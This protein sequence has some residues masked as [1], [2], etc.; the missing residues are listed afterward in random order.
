M[1]FESNTG[2]GVNNYYGPRDTGGTEGVV[3]TE[4]VMNEFMKDY[5]NAET[6]DFGFPVPLA[7]QDSYW[8]TEVDV[9]QATGTIT[10]QTIGGVDVSAA[11]PEAPVEIVDTNTGVLAFSGL[12]GGKVLIKYKKYA[13]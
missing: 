2:L 3:R 13:L 6:L 7:T 9:S 5:D 4:G 12:T 8:V 11:T 10:T 1:G